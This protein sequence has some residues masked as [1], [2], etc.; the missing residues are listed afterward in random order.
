MYNKQLKYSPNL[1]FPIL[2]L[3][4]QFPKIHILQHTLHHCNSFV[5]SNT[6]K[7][8]TEVRDADLGGGQ[9]QQKVKAGHITHMAADVVYLQTHQLKCEYTLY[10]RDF[11]YM[12]Q[13]LII[14]MILNT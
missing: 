12:N 8:L 13:T 7:T 3:L 11:I 9:V 10:H 14:Y 4:H 5:L 2:Y 1:Y 6:T